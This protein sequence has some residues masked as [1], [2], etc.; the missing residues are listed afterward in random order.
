MAGVGDERHR[1]ADD[2]VAGLDEDIGQVQRDPDHEGAAKGFA[3]AAGRSRAHAAA[4]RAATPGWP[5]LDS[6]SALPSWYGIGS[7]SSRTLP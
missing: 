4:R 1:I 2:S 7:L 3:F 5:S 6:A